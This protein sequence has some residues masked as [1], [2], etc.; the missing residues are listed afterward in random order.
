MARQAGDS[1]ARFKGDPV[2]G[3]VEPGRRGRPQQ[4]L[5]ALH[6]LGGQQ[7]IEDLVII[8]ERDLLAAGDVAEL[9]VVGKE[10]GRREFRQVGVG[11]IEVHV[12]AL[13][14]GMGHDPGF[15]KNHVGSGLQRV[16]ERLVREEITLANFAGTKGGQLF[17]RARALGKKRHRPA[18]DRLAARHPGPGEG[19]A[20]KV[21]AALHVG[22]ELG[23][24][25]RFHGP[26]FLH[27]FFPRHGQ[28]RRTPRAFVPA[29]VAVDVERCPVTADA[30]RIRRQFGCMI[31]AEA[32]VVCFP[33]RRLG[34]ATLP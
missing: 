19:D 23:H 21:V 2:R 8:G 12:H 32:V 34:S 18:H 11:D 10:H 1:G 9:L 6:L 14:L 4:L 29:G 33:I 3:L 30:W 17:V 22:L 28:R 5:Q 15:R 7:A 16:R 13:V 31:G 24:E 26:A 25:L 27:P 20:V